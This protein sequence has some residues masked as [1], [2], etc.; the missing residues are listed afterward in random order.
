MKYVG[1][2]AVAQLGRRE[3]SKYTYMGPLLQKSA[4]GLLTRPHCG[5]FVYIFIVFRVRPSLFAAVSFV[6]VLFLAV[7]S[8]LF[9]MPRNL[10]KSRC[11]NYV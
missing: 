11:L 5:G 6:V 10:R 2:N 8:G 1:N 7:G 3:Y 4:F 9:G